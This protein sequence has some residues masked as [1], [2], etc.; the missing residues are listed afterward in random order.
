MRDNWVRIQNELAVVLNRDVN[1]V[2]AR[3]YCLPLEKDDI[4]ERMRT[5]GHT[6]QFTI[7]GMRNFNTIQQSVLKLVVV[8]AAY[9][10]CT[11]RE[12]YIPWQNYVIL[13]L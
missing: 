11:F 3:F 8:I 12:L 13:G 7:D 9:L 4:L 1:T 2:D 5:Q 10:L 6:G